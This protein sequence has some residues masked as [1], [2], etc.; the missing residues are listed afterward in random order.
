MRDPDN[1][2]GPKQ[3]R[4]FRDVQDAAVSL[5]GRLLPPYDRMAIVTFDRNAGV[6]MNLNHQTA[7]G[8]TNAQYLTALGT[9]IMALDIYKFPGCAG[10]PPSPAGCTSTNTADGLKAAGNQFGLFKREEAVWIVILLTDGGANAATDSLGAWI[11]PG[12]PGVANWVEPFCRDPIAATRHISTNASYDPD[13]AARDLG[14]WVGCLDSNSATHPGSCA[15][16]APTYGQGA[17]IFTIGLGELVTNNTNCD[18]A[19]WG[20]SCELDV[21]EKLLRY[22]ASV[23]DDGNPTTN[24]CSTAGVGADCG[25]YYFSP[26]GAGLLE[27]FEAIA[28]RIFT[29]I[30]H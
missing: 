25:N 10:Y 18:A 28:S 12:G 29:R 11:C 15:A 6:A 4:P 20:G 7:F 24:P 8:L 27:V 16:L 1:C 3:C 9:Q 17:V 14:D 23:G 2:N 19:T 13:D 26:T 22:I 21:G 30:T 5:T